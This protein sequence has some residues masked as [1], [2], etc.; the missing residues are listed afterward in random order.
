M[1]DVQDPRLAL[2][3]RW[4]GLMRFLANDVRWTDPATG[5]VHVGSKAVAAAEMALRKEVTAAFFPNPAEGANTTVLP[6]NW[7]LAFT[8]KIDRKVDPAAL[9]SLRRATV[10][11]MADTLRAFGLNPEQFDQNAPV[12]AALGINLDT[13]IKHVPEVNTKPFKE[14]TAERR[15]VVELCLITKP[16]SPSLEIKEPAAPRAAAPLAGG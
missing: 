7:R 10:G 13:V 5:E 15:A 6:G 9:D 1:S 16:A 3:A 11:G 8:N 12:T 4:D 14:L 2:L